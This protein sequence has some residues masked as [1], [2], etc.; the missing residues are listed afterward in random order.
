MCNTTG[1]NYCVQATS[2]TTHLVPLNATIPVLSVEL[3]KTK[4]FPPAG[5]EY[6]CFQINEKSSHAAQCVKSRIM[7]KDINSILS[8]DTFFN[9]F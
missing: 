4:Q 8:V 2:A 7:N 5:K 3:H 6:L 9:V 1:K